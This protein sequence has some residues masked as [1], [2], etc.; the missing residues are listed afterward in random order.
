MSAVKSYLA[1]I[2]PCR[3][4]S[5]FSV[6][7]SEK[8]S[9]K[10]RHRMF[11]IGPSRSSGWSLQ[12]FVHKQITFSSLKF[13]ANSEKTSTYDVKVRKCPINAIRMSVETYANGL[14]LDNCTKCGTVLSSWN[15]C[16]AEHLFVLFWVTTKLNPLKQRF[17][18][19][20]PFKAM[21]FHFTVWTCAV[22]R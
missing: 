7:N 21:K 18:W 17:T 5:E 16:M 6:L 9:G 4:L 13:P 20:Q 8:I 1:M 3:T 11:E 15:T 19:T 12:I 10:V 14:C 2:Y 22:S